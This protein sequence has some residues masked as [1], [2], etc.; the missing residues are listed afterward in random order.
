M[1]KVVF[2]VATVLTI[3]FLLCSCT[4]NSTIEAVIVDGVEYKTVYLYSFENAELDSNL[5]HFPYRN[6]SPTACGYTY[7]SQKLSPGDTINV[8]SNC[9]YRET[10]STSI[11]SSDFGTNAVVTKMIK[12]YQISIREAQ[13]TYIIT[14][15]EFNRD[16]ATNKEDLKE[17]KRNTIEVVKERVTIKYE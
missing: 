8:W 4:T 12:T 14:Y 13:D 17:I 5:K 3:S 11:N 15:Y 7:S 16:T 9:V 1:K 10:S 2:M 6:I